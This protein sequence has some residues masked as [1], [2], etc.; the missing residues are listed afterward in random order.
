MSLDFLSK[1]T[2]WENVKQSKARVYWS[3]GKGLM[4]VKC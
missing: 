2:M 4:E 3:G 1:E